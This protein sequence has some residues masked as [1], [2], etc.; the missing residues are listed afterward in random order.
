MMEKKLKKIP[1]KPEKSPEPKTNNT[2]KLNKDILTATY[3]FMGLFLILTVYFAYFAGYSSREL[4]NNPYN[5]L[6]NLLAKSVTRGNIYSS[7]N[8]LLATTSTDSN[9]EEYRYY[10]YSEEYC[11]VVGSIGQG[12]YGLESAY[13][14]ELLSSNTGA[15]TKIINDFSG[16]KDAGDSLITT[17]DSEI[18]AAAYNA[19]DGY[20]GAVIVM[21]SKTGAV[22]AMVS[23]PD[24]NRTRF[25]RT[26]MRLMRMVLPYY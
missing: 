15:M 12:Q 6:Q 25:L 3:I 22:K 21:N 8:K 16:K 17:L 11:H 2:K 24:Y 4:I 19:L 1:E 20:D 23:G 5:K 14:F 7:D 18:Q 10:P 26:G 13:N 9:G